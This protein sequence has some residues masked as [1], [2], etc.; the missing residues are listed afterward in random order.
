MLCT[1]TLAMSP[2]SEDAHFMLCWMFAEA[3]TIAYIATCG[4]RE[5]NDVELGVSVSGWIGEGRMLIIGLRNMGTRPCVS[6]WRTRRS[7][8]MRSNSLKRQS[9]TR[10]I[11]FGHKRRRRRRR[12]AAGQR[13]AGKERRKSE[14][15]GSLRACFVF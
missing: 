8:T 4:D 3:L 2:R 1:H 7:T 14:K 10:I 15:R 9:R 6:V 13:R 11:E 12:E 5:C